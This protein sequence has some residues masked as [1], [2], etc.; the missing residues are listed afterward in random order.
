MMNKFFKNSRSLKGIC[1]F[2]GRYQ[3]NAFNHFSKSIEPFKHVMSFNLQPSFNDSLSTPH[4][5]IYPPKEKPT[6]C[7]SLNQYLIH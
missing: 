7:I 3:N 5:P 6:P 1:K 2:L 4:V